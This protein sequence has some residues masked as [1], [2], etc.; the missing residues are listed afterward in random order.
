MAD[1]TARIIE[2]HQVGWECPHCHLK[3]GKDKMD[4][5]FGGPL[6]GVDFACCGHGGHSNLSGGYISFTN[7]TVIRFP[8]DQLTVYTNEQWEKQFGK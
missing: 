6:P 8:K 5:C 7:G 1:K 3:R 4:P 2:Q